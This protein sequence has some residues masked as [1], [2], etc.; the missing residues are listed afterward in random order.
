MG[1]AWMSMIRSAAA[2]AIRAAIW[3]CRLRSSRSVRS[4]SSCQPFL[5]QPA[6]QQGGLRNRHHDGSDFHRQF[7]HP[8]E[9]CDQVLQAGQEPC[10][11]ADGI[12][13]LEA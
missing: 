7:E 6:G 5:K 12:A 2:L 4:V 1:C 8:D 11:H 3:I 9:R 10:Q 13:E